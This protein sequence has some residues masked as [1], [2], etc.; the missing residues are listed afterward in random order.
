MYLSKKLYTDFGFKVVGFW[1]IPLGID[2]LLCQSLQ[3]IPKRIEIFSATFCLPKIHEK[4]LGQMFGSFINTASRF[5]TNLKN[6]H[7]KLLPALCE[8]H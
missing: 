3:S 2:V 7:N 4:C 1:F 5:R 6:C 8:F